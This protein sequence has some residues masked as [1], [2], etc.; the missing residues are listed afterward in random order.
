M[1]IVYFFYFAAVGAMTPY[2]TVYY[3]NLGLSGKEI[4][5]LMSALPVLLFVSQPI[6]APLADRAG[7]R[8]R[9]LSRMM[10][11]AAVSGLLLAV[12]K[13]FWALLPMVFLWSFISGPIAPL[14]DSIALGEV[15]A[16]GTSYPRLRLWGSIGFLLV[17]TIAG[18]L[19]N[20]IDLR[21]S[22]VIY[23]VLLVVA[24]AA[25]QRLPADGVFASRPVFGQMRQALK[26]GNLVVF[27][28]LSSILTLANAAHAA[29]FSIHF[30]SI[31]GS[32]G[33]LGLAWALAAMMEVPVWLVLGRVT[34]RFGAAP[35][36]TFGA[37]A[38]GVRYFLTGMVTSPTVL[39]GLQLSQG[40]TMAVYFPT[41]V[42]FMGEL[43]PKE[44][45]T[46]GQALL[47]LVNGGLATVVGNLAAGWIVD[48]WGTGLLYEVNGGVATLAGLGFAI[49]LLGRGAGRKEEESLG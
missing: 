24:V 45:R 9:L 31:G 47:S 20:S 4:S 3:H 36:M 25:A 21:W 42:V 35:L 44:L 22:F 39:L 6:F 5:V 38:Y 8:G 28:I 27:L 18:R 11:A 48:R 40:L 7:H 2:M 32:S 16:T 15:A 41:S 19:Y 17:T 30:Q 46:S 14:C 49:F 23:A 26:N 34:D 37:L 29:F 43:M 12:G 1:S 13:T 33:Q 10:L